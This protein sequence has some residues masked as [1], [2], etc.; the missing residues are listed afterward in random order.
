M[1]IERMED[2]VG[3]AIGLVHADHESCIL[4]EL[5]VNRAREALVRSMDQTDMPGA[6]H[7]AIHRCEGVDGHDCPRHGSTPVQE[8]LH[9]AVERL[10]DL[11]NP[12]FALGCGQV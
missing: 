6:S 11:S 7:I 8:N 3:G 1:P 10:V 5:R 12:A 9:L 4:P 2:A